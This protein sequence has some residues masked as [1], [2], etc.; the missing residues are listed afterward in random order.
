LE[1]SA[2]HLAI[3]SSADLSADVTAASVLAVGGVQGQLASACDRFPTIL[4]AAGVA[5][6]AG[7]VVDG[8]RLDVGLTGRRD[9]AK[10]DEFLMHFPH[11]HRTNYFT[12]FRRGSAR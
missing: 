5:L 7:H 6:P 1:S 8:T 11:E 4:A 10:P 12:A 3:T 9:S 2:A